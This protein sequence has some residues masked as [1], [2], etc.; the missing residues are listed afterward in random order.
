MAVTLAEE[1]MLLAL[2]DESGY[3]RDRLMLGWPVAGAVVLELSLAERI[4]VLC[5][6]RLLADGPTDLVRRD[7]AVQRAYLG[8]GPAEADATFGSAA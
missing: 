6:G 3:A 1:I 7:T 5:E 2:D 8:A 4:T